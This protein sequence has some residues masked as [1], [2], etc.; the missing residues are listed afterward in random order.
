MNMN[1]NMKMNKR[2]KNIYKLKTVHYIKIYLLL[3]NN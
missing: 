2:I 1:M 3:Y